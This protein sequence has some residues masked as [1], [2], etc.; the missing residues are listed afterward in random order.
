MFGRLAWDNSFTIPVAAVLV[1]SYLAFQAGRSRFSLAV[2]LT[3]LGLLPLIHLMSLAIVVPFALHLLLVHRRALLQHWLVVVGAAVPFALVGG[4]YL[5]SLYADYLGPT[6]GVTAESIFRLNVEGMLFP[7]LGSGWL[8]PLGFGEHFAGPAWQAAQ[9]WA[10]RALGAISWLALPL[11]WFGIWLCA[12]RAWSCLRRLAD[13]FGAF[14][15]ELAGL[16]LTEHAMLLCLG[17]LLCQMLLGVLT[18]TFGLPHYFNSTWIVHAL[19]VWLGFD[20]LVRRVPR[21]R[22]WLPVQAVSLLLFLGSFA[23]SMHALGGARWVRHGPTIAN[24]IEVARALAA[25]PPHSGLLVEVDHDRLLQNSV[26]S[27]AELLGLEIPPVRLATNPAALSGVAPLWYAIRYAP[28]SPPYA[29][30]VRL[31]RLK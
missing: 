4:L 24:Q 17:V 6:A 27:L 21:L 2:F 31:E 15:T 23:W 1:P 14:A 30:R 12:R 5:S 26:M 18:G 3:C 22:W 7:W 16:S 13:G 25:L 9:P 11:A 19:F 20:A 29:A 8:T 10:W 28:G